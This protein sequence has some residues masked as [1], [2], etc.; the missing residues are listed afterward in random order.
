MVSDNDARSAI[1]GGFLIVMSVRADENIS[2]WNAYNNNVFCLMRFFIY[3]GIDA[4]DV[5]SNIFLNVDNL[6]LCLF[7][8]W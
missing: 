3:R 6:C 8:I 7:F 4:F 1:A 5:Y 2:D